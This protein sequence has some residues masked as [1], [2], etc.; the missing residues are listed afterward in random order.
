MSVEKSPWTKLGAE[1]ICE[2]PWFRVEEHDVIDPSGG[3]GVYYKV[4]FNNRAVAI[5]ALNQSQDLF[6]VGQHRYTLGEYSWELPM[7]GA[8]LDEQP[9]DAAR[10]EL[11]E[12]T[13]LRADEW[14]ELM[15]LHPS[16]SVTDEVGFV[17]LATG[18]TPGPASPEPTED[19][20]VRCL[21]LREAVDWAK[22]G[23]ITDAISVAAILR[24]WSDRDTLLARA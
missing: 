1:Q 8:A 18:L 17:F 24:L 13:G 10:R 9:L 15:R 16:N 12:E 7:G 22:S 21:P 11:Q 14:Q 20:R 2:N 6:L 3:R 23:K 4:C 5:L 19:L